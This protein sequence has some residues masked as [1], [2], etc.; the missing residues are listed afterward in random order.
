VWSVA[1]GKSYVNPDLIHVYIQDDMEHLATFGVES[2]LDQYNLVYFA[3]SMSSEMRQ[4][5]LD[6]NAHFTVNQDRQRV[7]FLLYM[8]AISPEFNL[9]Y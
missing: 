8:I 9:Q 2:L 5:L 1:E 4:T 7:S 6:L 3:G